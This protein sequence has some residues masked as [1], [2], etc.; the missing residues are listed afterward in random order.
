MLEITRN[1]T[2]HFLRWTE[3]WIKTDM[4][5]FT[6]GGFWLTTGQI[7]SVLSAFL[8]SIAFANLLPKETYGV[9]KYILSIASI[10]SI[11]TL[12]GISTALT[13]SVA[14]GFEGSLK[15]AVKTRIKWGLIG[16]T[17]SLVLAGYYFYNNNTTLTFS[18]LITAIFLPFM[19]SLSSYE[20]VLI[21]KK[22]FKTNTKYNILIKIIATIA[23]AG[24]LY[25]TDNILFIV[26]SYFI[27]YTTLRLIFLK[28]TI[29]KTKLND[30]QDTQIISYGKN[31]S[32]MDII[33]II[34]SQL[35]KILIFTYLGAAELGI[36]AFAIAVP[37][38]IKGIFKNI[39][40]LAL[41]KFAQSNYK[42]NRRS[43][44]IKMLKLS[45]VV[46]PIIIIYILVAP[47][48]FT[49]FFPQ[50]LDSIFYS[51]IF[52]ISLLTLPSIFPIAFLQS[53][54]AQ[55]KLYQ[56]ST[57]S[58][59]IQIVTLS[60]LIYFFGLMGIIAARLINRFINL[61]IAIILIDQEK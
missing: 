17:A 9:Y 38:Q 7:F 5:Y 23:T 3:K 40:T 26:F 48:I 51:Q 57:Y 6:Q 1:K 41:P 54:K 52:S 39:Y 60:I 49:W 19:D 33:G 24:T 43:I 13:Q 53:Q 14:K 20:A 34:T 35:D 44:L 47:Y 29:Y 30:K 28:I 61:F 32:F 59:T 46:L 58:P 50:Y 21:G 15:L 12:S 22:L 36:Y 11:P 55:R 16:S 2:Y 37:E 8:L 25:L 4:V 27:L 10:L 56:Y 31:L 18:F 42:E 45:L